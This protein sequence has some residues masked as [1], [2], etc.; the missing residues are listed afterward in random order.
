M[1]VVYELGCRGSQGSRNPD[2]CTFRTTSGGLVRE[3]KF[4]TNNM[5]SRYD[6]AGSPVY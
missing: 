5:I 2:L 3:I 4:N 1:E 6:G